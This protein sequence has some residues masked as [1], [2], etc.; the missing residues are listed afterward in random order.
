ML[1]SAMH[2]LAS[3]RS[4]FAACILAIGGMAADPDGGT[5][6]AA[7]EDA[8]VDAAPAVDATTTTPDATVAPA[9]DASGDAMSDGAAA[10]TGPQY[11]LPD[12]ALP[13]YNAGNIYDLLCIQDPGVVPFDYTSVK[14]PYADVAGCMAFDKIGHSAAHNCFCQ[15]CF[16]LQQQCDA[17]P[18]C[19]QIQK[20]E[21]DIG[22][23]TAQSCYL[24]GGPCVTPINNWGTGSVDTALTS[25]IA[26][27]GQGASP[28]CPSQ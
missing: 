24:G 3:R 19:Q 9:V 13:A 28:A 6:A 15:N 25:L 4:V 26:T 22:C 7:A 12:G 2:P 16:A 10:S 14:A 1:L 5:D 27:C 18:G 20:C 8:S 17:L 11:V 21:L 23:T